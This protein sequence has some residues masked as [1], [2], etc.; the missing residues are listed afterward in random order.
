MQCRDPAQLC[1]TCDVKKKEKKITN[2]F[3]TLLAIGTSVN[4][5]SMN[6]L[7]NNNMWWLEGNNQKPTR[8]LLPCSQPPAPTCFDE[9]SLLSPHHNYGFLGKN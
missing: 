4:T 8:N 6:K 3:W 2:T 9:S 7:I 1:K 5:N